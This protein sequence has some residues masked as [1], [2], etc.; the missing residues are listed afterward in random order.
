MSER[1]E[2]SA[3]MMSPDTGLHPHQA[4]R[5]IGKSRFHLPARPLLTQH[6]RT[7]RILADDMKRVLT[8]INADYGDRGPGLLRHRSAPRL[9]RPLASFKQWQGRSTAG[10]LGWCPPGFSWM[11]MTRSPFSSETPFHL[12]PK[13]ARVWRKAGIRMRSL[14]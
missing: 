10:L 7:L 13:F 6:N 9:W 1:V 5:H 14:A 12:T 11:L 2:A 3:E 4:W 8:N